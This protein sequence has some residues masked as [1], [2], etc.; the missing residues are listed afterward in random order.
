MLLFKGELLTQLNEAAE[1][2]E[3]GEVWVLNSLH[4]TAAWLLLGEQ[5]DNL[6][7]SGSRVPMS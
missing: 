1:N 6:P 7:V 3:I 4:F 2:E 5:R